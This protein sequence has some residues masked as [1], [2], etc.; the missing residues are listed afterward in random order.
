M[1]DRLRRLP[2]VA[3][4]LRARAPARCRAASAGDRRRRA[5]ARPAGAGALGGDRVHPLEPD[6]RRDDVRVGRSRADPAAVGRAAGAL[7]AE[8]RDRVLAGAAPAR[9]GRG[10]RPAGRR[11]RAG[12]GDRVR[13]S[14]AAVGHVRAAPRR[15]LPRGD[16][17]PRAARGGAAASQ[18]PDRVLRLPRARRRARRRVQRP[19]RADRVRPAHRIPDRAR[20]GVPRDPRLAGAAALA[21]ARR[22]R[23]AG[24]RR[25][26]SSSL[27]TPSA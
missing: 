7:P 14:H 3:G 10:L 18:L 15:V 4:R 22:R 11:R 12:A 25:R 19:G 16:R 8:L 21:A 2:R 20:A 9:G 23:A 17:L 27:P 1:V 6:A 5:G 13:R 26:R 24:G